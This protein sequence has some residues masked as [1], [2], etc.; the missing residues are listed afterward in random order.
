MHIGF[1]VSQP[2]PF[3]FCS[4]LSGHSLSA[5][6]AVS[7]NRL[8]RTAPTDD[9]MIW[10]TRCDDASYCNW[11]MWPLRLAQWNHGKILSGRKA[12]SSL[13]FGVSVHFLRTCS[14]QGRELQL[15]FPPWP[16]LR[17]CSWLRCYNPGCAVSQ[18][19]TRSA[20]DS[21]RGGGGGGEKKLS[22]PRKPCIPCT[23]LHIIL[24]FPPLA[25]CYPAPIPRQLAANKSC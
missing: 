20:Q 9:D 7:R 24:S 4:T 17:P 12:L 18:P 8:H 13:G 19:G 25:S 11:Y 10:D 23:T 2:P 5:I 15:K 6:S 1:L 21:R 22:P 14:T 16:A 3:H